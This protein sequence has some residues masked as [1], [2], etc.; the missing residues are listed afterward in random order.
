[1]LRRDGAGD[2]GTAVENEFHALL[3]GDVLHDN[4]Q[5]GE[6]RVERLQ[7]GLH[8]RGF[9]IENVNARIGRL[10]VNAQRHV[11]FRHLA[12]RITAHEKRDEHGIH[13]VDVRH[14]LVA[15]GGRTSGVVFARIHNA[16]IACLHDLLGRCAI[17][18]V[19]R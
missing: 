3:R 14:S 7:R 19:A 12:L 15:V 1:M 17:G 6:I 11:E 18:K 9:T 5:I 16:A 8:K 13:I 4:L 10:A 2:V